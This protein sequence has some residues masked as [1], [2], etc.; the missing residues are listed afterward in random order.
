[1]ALAQF[2]PL[3]GGMGG[4]GGMSSG[5]NALLAAQMGRN[6][7]AGIGSYLRGDLP[8]YDPA[9]MMQA[10]MPLLLAREE[11]PFRQQ[12]H[13]DLLN[14]QREGMKNQESI[15]DKQLANSLSLLEKQGT[16][17]LEGLKEQ[18][19][20]LLE[21]MRQA[22]VGANL[23]AL[24]GLQGVERERQGASL[25]RAMLGSQYGSS[26]RQAKAG[27]AGDTLQDALERAGQEAEAVRGSLEGIEIPSGLPGSALWTDP[28]H[29]EAVTTVSGAAD[30]ISTLRSKLMDDGNSPAERFAAAQALRK[31]TLSP[32]PKMRELEDAVSGAW[33]RFPSNWLTSSSGDLTAA[34]AQIER[35]KEEIKAAKSSLEAPEIDLNELRKQARSPVSDIAGLQAETE[36]LRRLLEQAGTNSASLGTTDIYEELRK[37]LISQLQAQGVNP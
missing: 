7:N 22:G 26:V 9:S 4:G 32:L 10:W 1:M 11:R 12:E 14:L 2:V 20:P 5:L 19:K 16:I 15:L 34:R 21:Q 37:Q 25:Q 29:T 36:Q 31:L 30:R 33:T 6:Q 23:S 17:Q 8:S 24:L 28:I 3:G 27:E 35:L 13:A 18:Q